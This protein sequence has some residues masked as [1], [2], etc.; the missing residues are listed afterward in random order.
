TRSLTDAEVLQIARTSGR[1]RDWIHDHPVTRTTP[2][3]D[4]VKDEFTV[5]FVH[6]D[7]KGR[8]TTEAQ[9]FIADE[10]GEIT[11]VRTGPQVAWM[12]ARGYQGSFGRSINKVGVWLFLSALFLLP[13]LSRRLLS[14]RTLDLLALLSFSASLYWFNRGE[15]FTSVPLSYPPMLYLIA[16]LG[17]VGLRR[18]RAPRVPPPIGGR[19]LRRLVFPGWSPTWVL[20]TALCLALG[21]RYGLNAFDSNVID[22]GY[23]GVIGADRIQHGVTPYGTFPSDCGQCDTYGPLNYLAY[24]PFE[25]AQPWDGKW[26][27]LP[28]AHGAATAFDLLCVAGMLVLGW[29]LSG[30]RL[31]MALSLAWAAFPFTGYALLSNSND[32]LVAA[33]LIWGLV[34]A[35]RPLVRGLMLGLAVATKFGPAILALLWWR[36]PFPRPGRRREPVRFALGL[37]LAAVLTGWV[38]LLDGLKGVTAFWDRTLGYQLHRES[39][40]SV[41]GQHPGLRPLQVALSILVVL[42]ALALVR[43]PRHLDLL[44]VTALSGAV[45]LGTQLV[46][47][48]WF[49]LYIPWFLPFALLAFVPTWPPATPPRAPATEELPAVEPDPQP[50]P[51]PA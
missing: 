19:V 38:L 43:W 22:V 12:M 47:T 42:A 7:K 23:A 44:S 14:W 15:I 36:R 11:E 39:P 40:F 25:V 34:F 2:S 18:M 3:Y 30:L 29:R 51:E 49:Y 45:L 5:W 50:V 21:L 37:V 13:L 17:W 48:H 41:W 20:V 24:V 46:M 4:A 32:E 33:C 6:K 27:S 31:G 9:V 26:D 8:E 10:T 28:A 35:R 1:V 16:R